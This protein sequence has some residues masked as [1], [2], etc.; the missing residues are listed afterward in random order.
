M[1][2]KVKSVSP[3]PCYALEV[4]FENGDR[5]RYE[6]QPL[7]ERWPVFQNLRDMPGLF[8]QVQVDAGGYGI[9]W[10]DDIDLACNELWENGEPLQSLPKAQ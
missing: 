1:F 6:V 3:L 5:R 2:H 4:C 8:G 10:N 7:F 9:S